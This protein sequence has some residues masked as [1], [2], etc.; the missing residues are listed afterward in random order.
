MLARTRLSTGAKQ[1]TVYVEHG[2][3]YDVSTWHIH[4]TISGAPGSGRC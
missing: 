2:V 4:V 3:F 1:R